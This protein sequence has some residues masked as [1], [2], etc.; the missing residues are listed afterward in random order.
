MPYYDSTDYQINKR[1]SKLYKRQK[2]YVEAKRYTSR[3][4][5]IN[6][7]SIESL[8]ELGSI[9][10]KMKLKEASIACYSKVLALEPLHKKA[11]FNLDNLHS[12]K[13]DD[14][15]KSNEYATVLL[16]HYPSYFN[17]VVLMAKNSIKSEDYAKAK[18]CIELAERL[19]PGSS[20]VKKLYL[21]MAK[22]E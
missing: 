3:C 15:V 18:E 22:K 6:P 20:T 19:K 8:M 9:N 7:N 4:L 17:G 14:M 16:K 13:M 10:K 2:K 5:A 1:I 12:K 21:K 11:L